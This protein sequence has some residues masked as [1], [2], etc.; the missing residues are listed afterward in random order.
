MASLCLR[1]R[2]GR[3][4]FRYH[5]LAG[6]SFRNRSP[7]TCSREGIGNGDIF[8]RSA[9][10]HALKAR[11][12]LHSRLLGFLV[13]Y[14]P[15]CA[16]VTRIVSAVCGAMVV[17]APASIPAE[18]ACWRLNMCRTRPS[19]RSDKHDVDKTAAVG[20]VCLAGWCHYSCDRR[21]SVCLSVL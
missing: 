8:P 4:R 3:S 18:D 17:V 2:R 21:G 1:L 5:D 11:R 16:I 10:E 7:C 13:L 6:S 12:L 15:G 20:P 9:S 14:A 19:V